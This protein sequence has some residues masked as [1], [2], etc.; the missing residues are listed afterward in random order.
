MSDEELEYVSYHLISSSTDT[1][2]VQ[3][4]SI[5]ERAS[6]PVRLCTGCPKNFRHSIFI[7]DVKHMSNVFPKSA[8]ALTDRRRRVLPSNLES[9]MF[10]HFFV[11]L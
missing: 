9:Q 11:N 8:Y 3:D 10:L 5:L 4:G 6:K 7:A 1:D 2:A